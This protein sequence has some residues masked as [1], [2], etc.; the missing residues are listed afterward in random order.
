MP[1]WGLTVNTDYMNSKHIG[2]HT[3][4]AFKWKE[5]YFWRVKLNV[6]M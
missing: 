3:E 1:P 4:L 2:S 5:I 6:Y